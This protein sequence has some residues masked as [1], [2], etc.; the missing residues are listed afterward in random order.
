M[1]EDVSPYHRGWKHGNSHVSNPHT[2]KKIEIRGVQNNFMT[3]D[4]TSKL[5][6]KKERW[7]ISKHS[8]EGFPPPKEAKPKVPPAEQ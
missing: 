3:K 5:T 1:P 6:T 4:D 8:V 2:I 7:I